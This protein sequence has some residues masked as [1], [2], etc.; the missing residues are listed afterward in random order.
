MDRLYNLR[1]K[2][3]LL[4]QIM[5]LIIILFSC[6]LSYVKGQSIK[7]IK[8]QIN[9]R[10]LA[11]VK[12]KEQFGVGGGY[13]QNGFN[14]DGFYAKYWR[15]DIIF[16]TDINYETASYSLTR[17]NWYY[18]SPEIN[19]TIQKVSNRLFINAKAGV[20]LGKEYL[21]NSIMVNH[22]L[23]KLSIGEKIGFKIEYF[24]TPDVSLNIDLEQRFINNSNLGTLS[25][26][27]LISISYNY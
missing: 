26:I 25:N 11:H 6:E 13:V 5:F 16:R 2:K 9:Y 8:R 10:N 22:K 4:N 7:Q 21:S 24:L 12:D 3:L 1:C 15:K 18:I 19:Y 23:N 14:I 17:M 20:I 27:A